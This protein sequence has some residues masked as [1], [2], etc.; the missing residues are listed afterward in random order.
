MDKDRLEDL[1]N[2]FFLKR[3]SDEEKVEFEDLLKSSDEARKIFRQ[4]SFINRGLQTIEFNKTCT[5]PEFNISLKQKA[6]RRTLW[7]QYIR[8]AAAVLT[9]PL[10]ISLL[11]LLV[12][13]DGLTKPTS[14]ELSY[15]NTNSKAILI[16]LPDSSKVYLYAKSTLKYPSLFTDHERHVKLT[17]EATFEVV[18]D[19][20]NP[21]Y[22]ET[23]DGV[24]I[25]AYG[26]K[27]NVYGYDDDDIVQVYLERG[28]VNFSSPYL[29]EP[30]KMRAA[31]KLEFSRKNKSVKVSPADA[32]EYEAYEKGVLLFRS[33]SLERIAKKLSRVY[34]IDI[35]I[36]DNEIRYYPITGVF[37]DK[38][39]DQIMDLLQM[40]SPGLKWKREE[41]KIVLYKK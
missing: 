13:K 25:K 3:L 20:E 39:V 36:Q 2:K 19:P 24:K 26:T 5:P 16:T 10:L 30:T 33:A 31:T 28:K 9:I 34:D 35:D 4:W 7:M 15:T 27:F 40:S 37:E 29:S 18:S 21:F 6:K 17:G 8:N 11:Y 14:Y 12:G 41:D 38:S 23:L 32:S 1:I 22:V